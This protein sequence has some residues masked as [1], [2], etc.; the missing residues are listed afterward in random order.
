MLATQLPGFN[1]A[2]DLDAGTHRAR[3]ERQCGMLSNEL[4]LSRQRSRPREGG[5]AH[6]EDYAISG[7]TADLP[8]SLTRETYGVAATSI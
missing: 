8:V 6:Y 2:Y 5:T 3:V 7:M 4:D 1:A